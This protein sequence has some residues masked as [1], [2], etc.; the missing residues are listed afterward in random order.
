MRS[1]GLLGPLDV[2]LDGRHVHVPPGKRR[3]V[4]AALLLRPGQVVGVD[5]L[6]ELVGGSRNAL[7]TTVGRLR[8]V[9]PATSC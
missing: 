4:L 5:E 2:V 9:L 8:E 3:V 7:Q 6:V 1:F